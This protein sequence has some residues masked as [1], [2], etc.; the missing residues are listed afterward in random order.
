LLLLRLLLRGTDDEEDA[1]SQR[2]A[3]FGAAAGLALGV[4]AAAAVG[5][6][7]PSFAVAVVDER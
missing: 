6:I 7:F 4:A 1:V 2:S 3:A 5:L